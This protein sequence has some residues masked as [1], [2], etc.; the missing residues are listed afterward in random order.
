MSHELP[1]DFRS[2]TEVLTV[3]R[4]READGLVGEPYLI[5]IARD[6]RRLFI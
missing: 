2:S 6:D 1:Q 4:E 5:D 3:Y